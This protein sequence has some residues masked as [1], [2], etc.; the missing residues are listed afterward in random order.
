MD[1]YKGNMSTFN[2]LGVMLLVIGSVWLTSCTKSSNIEFIAPS[3]KTLEILSGGELEVPVL[4]SGWSI[5]SVKYM[6]SGEAVLDHNGK[7]LTLKGNGHVAASSGW[8]TLIREGNDKFTIQLKENFDASSERKFEIVVTDKTGGEHYI[9]VIQKR[10]KGYKLVKSEF[11]ESEDQRRVYKSGEGCST[12]TLSNSTSEAIWKPYAAIFENVVQSSNFE[13]SNYGAFGWLPEEGVH[14]S[15][16][17]LII[18]NKMYA[19][20]RTI[21]KEGITTTPYIKDRFNDYKILVKP[22]YTVYLKGEITYCKRVFNYT[23]TVQNTDTGAQF[24]VSGIWIQIVPIANNTI[25]S[26]K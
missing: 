10:G 9:T 22:Y 7:P 17:D 21:Y 13:S 24:K 8:L 3:Y 26:D 23:L 11:K 25:I 6:P 14:I 5:A 15:V 16:P 18:E 2:R 4:T 20:G 19:T 1:Q 12:L